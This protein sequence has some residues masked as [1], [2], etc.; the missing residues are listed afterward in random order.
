MGVERR[1]WGGMWDLENPGIDPSV[2]AGGLTQPGFGGVTLGC[3][4]TLDF[5]GYIACPPA[6]L[7]ARLIS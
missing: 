1:G 4:H 5:W 2:A 3:D 6:S 7:L